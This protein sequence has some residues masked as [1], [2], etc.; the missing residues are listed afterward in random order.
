MLSAPPRARAGGLGGLG[1]LDF[2]ALGGLGGAGGLG[3]GGVGAGAGGLAGLGSAPGMGGLG[4]LGGLGGMAGGPTPEQMQMMVAQMQNPMFRELM[5]QMVS[6]PGVLEAA[7]AANPQL[8]QA[9]DQDP[10]LRRAPARGA[11]PPPPRP[12]PAAGAAARLSRGATARA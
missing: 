5:T 7:T 12:G 3:G 10:H 4:G 1:G 9:L 11:P 6:Q 2:G 8:R